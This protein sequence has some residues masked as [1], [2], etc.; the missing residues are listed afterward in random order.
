MAGES[1][2]EI[3]VRLIA[4]TSEFKAQMQS[5][6]D[7]VTAS[8]AQMATASAQV[9]TTSVNAASAEIAARERIHAA[10]TASL[11]QQAKEHAAIQATTDATVRRTDALGESTAASRAAAE[12]YGAKARA[13]MEAMAAED[14]QSAA[15]GSNTRRTLENAAA[16]STLTDRLKSGNASREYAALLDEV[17]RHR[18]SQMASTTAVLS[19]RLG[20]LRLAFSPLGLA[21]L[22]VAAVIG[23]FVATLIMAENRFDKL[24]D[25]LIATGDSSGTTAGELSGMANVIAS[26]VGTIGGA[27]DALAALARSGKFAADEMQAAGQAAVDMAQLTG[28]KVGATAKMIESLATDPVK[29]VAKLNESFHFLTAAQFEVIDALQKTGHS[30][31]ATKLALEDMGNVM[32]PRAV[33]S[34]EDA[35]IFVRGWHHVEN[36]ADELG[37]TL[38][39]VFGGGGLEGHLKNLKDEMAAMVAMNVPINSLAREQLATEIATTE[40]AIKANDAKAKAVANQ[41]ALNQAAIE[42]KQAL[43][44]TFDGFK[45]N[46]Q[47]AAQQIAKVKTELEALHAATPGASELAGMTFS[48]NVLVGG[49]GWEKLKGE[50]QAKFDAHDFKIHG[51]VQIK[52]IKE[53]TE[54]DKFAGLKI[55]AAPAA[56]GVDTAKIADDQIR[57][58]QGSQRVGAEMAKVQAAA[59]AEVATIDSLFK[60]LDRAFDNT[61]KGVIRGTETWHQ[62]I[63][64]MGQSLEQSFLSTLLNMTTNWLTMEATKTAASIAGDQIRTTSAVSSSSEATI[65]EVGGAIKVILA[66]AWQAAAAVYS[67]VSDIPFVGW[68][69]APA[70]AIAAGVEVASFAGRVASA[71]GGWERVPHDQMAMVHKNEMVLPA[72]LAEGVRRNMGGRGGTTNH[73]HVN[74]MDSRSIHEALRRNP[75]AVTGALHRAV[76]LGAV[77]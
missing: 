72:Q 32:H 76:K 77:G 61:V 63:R 43:D 48:G 60:T 49:A 65:A 16:Q 42:G 23:G 54:S 52:P 24:Q 35:N 3:L 5:A 29:A 51:S 68:I 15:L 53:F 45:N 66:K 50:L 34:A 25:A 74:A 9:S 46:A 19:N 1:D 75:T 39:R 37:N 30:A 12:A 57:M 17:L 13:E 67:S 47:L 36:A 31:E 64:K 59:R 18:Y 7:A 11:A 20:L 14:A 21:I 2:N 40:A 10:I 55:A 38:N 8:N 62:G 70:M 6:A 58:F 28:E 44:A 22:G 41:D 27:T 4:Q 26:S 73:Y 56:S 69:L 71:A 33:Q